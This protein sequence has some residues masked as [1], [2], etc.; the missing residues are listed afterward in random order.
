MGPGI[1]VSGTVISED[2]QMP[3]PGVTIQVEGTNKGVITD[4]DGNYTIKNVDPQATLVYSYL[5]FQT[6]K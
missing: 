5:G 2:D 3:L 4:F 6:K 1:E